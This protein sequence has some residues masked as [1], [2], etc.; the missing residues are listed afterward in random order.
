MP[1][2]RPLSH[3][4][5]R[6]TPPSRY[7]FT[8]MR[9][10]ARSR[11][12]SSS[13][14]PAAPFVYAG[15]LPG[16]SIEIAKPDKFVGAATPLEVAVTA[17]GRARCRACRSPSSRTASRRRSTR[18]GRPGSAAD[19]AGRPRHGRSRATIGKQTRARAQDRAPA[20]II[21]TAAR[22]VLRGMR[23]LD[24]DA[25]RRDVQVRLE[26][27]RVA[28]ALDASLHQPRRH[29]DGRL[30]RR[31]RTT[32]SRACWSAT[33]SIP[34]IP[35]PAR[36]VEGVTITDPALRVA[37]FALRYDQDLNTPMRALRARRGRQHRARRLRLHR[38]SRSRSRRAASSSTTSSSIAS[39][40]RSS[41]ARPRSSPTGDTL[42]KF[43]VI[44]GELRRKNAEKIASFAK[45]TSPEIL[46]GGVVFH[47]F[48]NNAVESAFA[49]HRTYVYKGKEVDQ[50]VAPRLRPRVV[51]P[52]RRSSRRTAARCCSRT[53][54]AS[55][56]TA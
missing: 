7:R 41:R 50:Q 15:R 23:T 31:R 21:V 3:R 56:A 5:P 20:R 18:S 45:Q 9:Y 54:S 19:E 53:S 51:S 10:L 17:P 6:R 32:W 43:L 49:D 33:S 42:A 46:W 11:P 55:T 27:P 30:S 29:R 14:R 34:A 36:S 39:C 48:T 37:F 26:R 38:R 12:S 28:V 16:P 52:T 40:R 24:V 2:A 35:R 25:P 47:P 13:W 44:N 22:P 1:A 4:E 8:S